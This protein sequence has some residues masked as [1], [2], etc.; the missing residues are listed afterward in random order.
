MIELTEQ[1][2]QALEQADALPPRVINP[3]TQQ[4][5]VLL[6]TTEYERLT[7]GEYDDSPW[8]DEETA[9]LAAEA[10]ELL[11]SFGRDQNSPTG[12]RSFLENNR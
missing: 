9:L 8:T 3:R 2:A 1:Q 5:F 4:T 12:S 11:D 7:N 6:S 10:G